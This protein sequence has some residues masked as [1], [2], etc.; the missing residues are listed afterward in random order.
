MLEKNPAIESVSAGDIMNP[1]PKFIEGGE[2][3]VDAMELMRRHQISQLAVV[4]EGRYAGILHLHD[5][6]REGIL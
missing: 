5:L 2:L 4:K 1:S 3:A 6:M